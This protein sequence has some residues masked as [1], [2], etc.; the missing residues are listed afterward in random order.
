[1][2]PDKERSLRLE[3]C[4]GS[5]VGVGDYSGP[6]KVLLMTPINQGKTHSKSLAPLASEYNMPGDGILKGANTTSAIGAGN[7]ATSRAYPFRCPASGLN[8]AWGYFSMKRKRRSCVYVIAAAVSL[9]SLAVHANEQAPSAPTDL[10]VY[11]GETRVI[12]F[13]SGAALDLANLVN[14]GTIY[15]VSSNP[16]VTSGVL[17]TVSVVNAA[18]GLIT[19]VLPTG[20]LAGFSNLV[21]N[22]SFTLAA[23]QNI[24]NL[25]TISSAGNLTIAAGGS[26]INGIAG[27][28]SSASMSAAAAL[29]MIAGSG[30]ILNSGV[31]TSATS[32]INIS[33]LQNSLVFQNQFGNVIASLGSINFRDE[34]FLVKENLALL[35]GNFSAREVNLF[36]GEGKAVVNVSSLAGVLNIY[37]GEAHVTT[38]TESL[39]LGNI[40]LSGDPTFFNTSGDIIINTDLRFSGQPLAIVARG[41]IV[42]SA[43]ALTIDT[44][45][46]TGDGGD[47]ALIAGFTARKLLA[48]ASRSAILTLLAVQ[49]AVA[50]CK[51]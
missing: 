20:G 41:D 24:T 31:L 44:S 51:C 30:T 19:S 37:A 39:N 48:P 6:P 23:Q 38:A 35:G 3:G 7:N 32:N 14:D 36:S 45:S 42:T 13:G 1:M 27:Q 17:N 46:T 29:S 9:Q 33:A 34:N 15:L 16:Q 49:V 50:M 25:G 47:I 10:N 22:F 12:D 11:T 43:G 40:V 28:A 26:V 2:S 5:P 8:R 18:S 4:R 21:P